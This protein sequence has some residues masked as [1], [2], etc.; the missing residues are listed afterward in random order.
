MITCYLT[1]ILTPLQAFFCS[2]SP[3]VK[4]RNFFNANYREVIALSANC[5]TVFTAG[6]RKILYGRLL[7]HAFHLHVLYSVLLCDTRDVMGILCF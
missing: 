3:S 4:P 6:C 1:E 5:T 2:S 7:F